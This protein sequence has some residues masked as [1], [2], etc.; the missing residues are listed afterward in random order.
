MFRKVRNTLALP[1][2]FVSRSVFDEIHREGKSHSLFNNCVRKE[3][4]AYVSGLDPD[5]FLLGYGAENTLFF[6]FF[7]FIIRLGLLPSTLS[8]QGHTFWRA[9]TKSWGI[10]PDLPKEPKGKCNTLDTM[11]TWK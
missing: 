10:P 3:I 4:L 9:A 8:A 6:F 2:A 11:Q 5:W 1:S 7:F